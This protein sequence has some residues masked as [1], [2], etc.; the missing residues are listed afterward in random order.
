MMFVTDLDKTFLRSDLSVSEFSKQVWNGFKYPITIATARSYKGSVGLLK[1]LELKYPL[2]LLD[3]AMIAKPDGEI[4]EINAIE[5]F[6]GDEIIYEVYKNFKD[7]PLIVGFNE[8][9]DEKFLYP[10]DLNPYQ[11][12]LLQNYKND[13][14]VLNIEKLKALNYN[15]KM[16]YLGEKEFLEKVENFIKDKF[17][18]ETKLIEDAY[19]P[20][21]FLTI[22]DK[23]ADKA[24]GLKHLEEIVGI[25]KE[26]VVVFGDNLNDIG[27]FEWAGKSIAVKN[28]LDEVK[29]KAD[30]VLPHTNDEDA[31]AR[32]LSKVV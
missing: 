31:V 20:Y 25:D 16:V 4:I 17:Y 10:K 9:G 6:L 11:K 23:E 30:I 26:K 13:S 22:L 24:S 5:K 15:L 7:Y 8:I 19:G 3:G 21:Y 29:K 2:I 28:A 18:V 27:M 14:R 32:Y 1:G 12:H